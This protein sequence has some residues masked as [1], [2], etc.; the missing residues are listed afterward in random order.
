MHV[1]SSRSYDYEAFK[2]KNQQKIFFFKKIKKKRK[3]KDPEWHSDRGIFGKVGSQF[4]TQ[5]R[6][7]PSSTKQENGDT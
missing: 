2:N 5:D 6:T 1:S 7:R 3:L 4:A